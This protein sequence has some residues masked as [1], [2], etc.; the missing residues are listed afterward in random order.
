MYVKIKLMGVPNAR[1]LSYPTLLPQWKAEDI[2]WT[3]AFDL[4]SIY[5]IYNLPLSMDNHRTQLS[6]PFVLNFYSEVSTRLEL[7]WLQALMDEDNWMML[8]GY[9]PIWK[10][11]AKF[12]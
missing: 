9:L 12:L 7:T 8:S 11:M 3:F 5:K 10:K 6:V 4:S 1:H 2:Q